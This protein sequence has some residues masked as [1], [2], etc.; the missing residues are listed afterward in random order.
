[1]VNKID[2]HVA[3]MGRRPG[4]TLWAEKVRCLATLSRGGAEMSTSVAKTNEKEQKKKQTDK[5]GRK[6]PVK[7]S[8]LV[9]RV[10]RKFEA[11]LQEDQYKVSVGDFVRLVQLEQEMKEDTPK[12]VRVTW[13]EPAEK[14]P[15]SGT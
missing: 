10:L 2:F 9:G 4:A 3:A 14:E 11:K 7:R 8:R 12:E 15:E 5:P 13:V 1:M 6:R